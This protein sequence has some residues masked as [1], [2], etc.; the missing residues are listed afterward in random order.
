MLL[1]YSS[2]VGKVSCSE[3]YT[4]NKSWCS[5]QKN[6]ENMW[7]NRRGF[8]EYLNLALSLIRQLV[9]DNF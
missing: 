8:R 1:A 4:A 9:T 3:N 6:Q 5:I 2:I 7:R